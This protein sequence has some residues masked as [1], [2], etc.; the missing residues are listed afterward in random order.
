MSELHAQLSN[1]WAVPVTFDTCLR[2]KS[3]AMFDLI[4]VLSG[5]VARMPLVF[6]KF[7][8]LGVLMQRQCSVVLQF[9][10]PS[11]LHGLGWESKRLWAVYCWQ[12]MIVCVC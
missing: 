4:W 8:L 10:M 2:F 7:L 3:H 1:L 11:F 5:C 12:Y 9:H 6:M